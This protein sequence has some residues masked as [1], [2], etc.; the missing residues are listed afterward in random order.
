MK[1]HEDEV[2]LVT[3][4]HNGESLASASKDH[5]VALYD[6][7][8]NGDLHMV[9]QLTAHA[10]EVTQV[11]WRCDD[12]YILTCCRTE[13]RILLMFNRILYTFL[14]KAKSN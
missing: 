1:I 4:S 14:H 5:S 7:F 13:V 8:P 10:H 11:L 6:V 9:T 12:T 3:F 2:W